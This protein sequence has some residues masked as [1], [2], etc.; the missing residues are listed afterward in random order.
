M[1]LDPDWHWAISSILLLLGLIGYFGAARWRH[2]LPTETDEAELPTFSLTN[3]WT[4]AIAQSVW[5]ITAVAGAWSVSRSLPEAWHPVVFLLLLFGLGYMHWQAQRGRGEFWKHLGF[6]FT[7]PFLPLAWALEPLNRILE[8]NYSAPHEQEPPPTPTPEDPRNPPPDQE[9]QLLLGLLS[10]GDK[11]AR[12]VLISRVDMAA[13]PA[14]ASWEEVRRAIE[15]SP[16]GRIPLY[17]KSP[18]DIL[19]ILYAKDL[20]PLLEQEPPT[21]PDW[22]KMA[23]PALFISPTIPLTELLE[24]LHR[25]NQPVAIVVDEFGGTLG[26]VTLE[27]VMWEIIEEPGED[28]APSPQALGPGEYRLDGRTS[29]KELERLLGRPL[30]SEEE[31]EENRPETVAGLILYHTGRVPAEGEELLLPG[32]LRFVIEEATARRIRRLRLQVAHPTGRRN[33]DSHSA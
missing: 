25:R 8:N 6:W 10:F 28:F 15:T 33:P 17:G 31:E 29:L 9:G 30:F 2:A 27:N 19:G 12:D 13:V 24:L 5:S 16:Y 14:S 22:S 21:R 18:D 26:M 11:T 4:G 1:D 23:R 32:G 7:F 20:L 3:P